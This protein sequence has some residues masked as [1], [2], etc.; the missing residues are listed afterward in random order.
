MDYCPNCLSISITMSKT[1]HATEFTCHR[2]NYEWMK[3]DETYSTS[4]PTTLELDRRLSELEDRMFERF[5]EYI[6]EKIEAIIKA[7]KHE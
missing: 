4:I 2:C 5:T 6:D 3:N 1:R 7:S